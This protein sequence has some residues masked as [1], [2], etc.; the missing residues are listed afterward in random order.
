MICAPR[1]IVARNVARLVAWCKAI[2]VDWTGLAELDSADVDFS[3]MFA[4]AVD[5]GGYAWKGF[6]AG[7]GDWFVTKLA[8]FL[9]LG[10]FFR[11]C[12][13]HRTAKNITKTQCLGS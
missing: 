5:A 3:G 2:A 4:G 12:F 1:P 11:Q 13:L 6:E 8:T 9:I 10:G 7:G